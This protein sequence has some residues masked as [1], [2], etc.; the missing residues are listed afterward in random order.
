LEGFVTQKTTFKFEAIVHD[1]AS[2]DGTAAI[3]LEYAEKYPDIIKPILESENQYSKLDGSL[4][5]IMYNNTHGRYVAV[6]EGD[7]YWT[8]PQKLQT[9]VEFMEEHPECSLLYTDYTVVSGGRQKWVRKCF[10]SGDARTLMTTSMQIVT[11]TVMFRREAMDGYN[12][13]ILNCPFKLL[14]GDRSLWL[15]LGSIGRIEYINIVSAVRRLA[16]GSLTQRRDFYNADLK[17]QKNFEDFEIWAGEYLKIGVPESFIRHRCSRL[18]VRMSMTYSVSVF[19]K[20]L[21]T[22]LRRYPSNILSPSLWK[23]LIAYPII[24]IRGL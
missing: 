6:C 1:D 7:D 4:S 19:A 18:R 9:Q 13:F 3:I 12:N 11:A 24:A 8:N 23:M 10:I 5:R 14:F 17:L 20:Q 2:T 22:E 16:P 21:V 15:Y